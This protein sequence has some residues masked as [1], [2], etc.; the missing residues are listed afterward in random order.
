[1]R[2]FSFGA[3]LYNI[4]MHLSVFLFFYAAFMTGAMT[5]LFGK[6]LAALNFIK[7]KCE[8]DLRFSLVRVRENAESI[9]MYDGGNTELSGSRGLLKKMIE[10]NVQVIWAMFGF[11]MFQNGTQY[12]TGLLPVLLVAP[13]YLAGEVNSTRRDTTVVGSIHNITILLLHRGIPRHGCSFEERND[14]AL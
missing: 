5:W 10:N 1:M 8:A 4:S 12:L 2:I 13:Q 7:R 9:A 14:V 11:E 3:I 6:R